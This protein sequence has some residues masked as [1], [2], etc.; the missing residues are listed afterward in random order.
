[1]I[2]QYFERRVSIVV[3]VFV[4]IVVIVDQID[5]ESIVVESVVVVIVVIIVVFVVYSLCVIGEKDASL[6]FFVVF[7]LIYYY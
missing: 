4:V 2:V 5:V 3:D 1:M 7:L 6:A